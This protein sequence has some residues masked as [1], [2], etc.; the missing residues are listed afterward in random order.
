MNNIVE[1]FVNGYPLPQ[2]T[3]NG[4]IF[5]V[6]PRD[7]D[8][9]IGVRAP[10]SRGGG[11]G[12]VEIVISV[13]GLGIKTGT[14]ASMSDRGYVARTGQLV[15]IPGWTVNNQS[16][17]RFR[18]AQVDDSYSALSARGTANVGVIGVAIFHE[19]YEAPVFHNNLESLPGHFPGCRSK[20]GGSNTMGMARLSASKS[21]DRGGD[22]GTAF[23]SK[24]D[25]NVSTTEFRRGSLDR[26]VS[27]FYR[28]REW[29]ER[30][31]IA[32]PGEPAAS[33]SAFPADGGCV[34]PPGWHG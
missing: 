20:H 30:N 34:P 8:Y 25:F 10:A 4:Q 33:G 7:C 29:F 22:S 24:V 9:E 28:S 18:F 16:A 12:R 21:M 26:T 13:D 15:K 6:N 11:T 19:H 2:F 14:P 31:G 3:H 17:A 23:G 32:I 27:L 1:I 5:V